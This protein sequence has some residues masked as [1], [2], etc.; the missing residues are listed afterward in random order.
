MKKGFFLF[1]LLLVLLKPSTAQEKLSSADKDAV[2]L[3]KNEASGGLNIHSNGWGFTFRRGWH[4]TGY[5]KH[6]LEFDL[7]SMRHPKQYKQANPY[8]QNSKP[9]YFGKLNYVFL[10]RG[11]YGRQN[12]LYSKGER[13]GVE[14]RY[15][16]GIGPV[17]A[18][19]KPVY[20]KVVVTR[21][22]ND[23]IYFE[24]IRQYTADDPLLSPEN[25]NG[26]GP[27]F[28]G[29]DKI[30]LYPGGWGRFSLSFE[31]AGWHEKITAIETGVI[32][33]YFPT[34]V[35][36]MAFN[37]NQNMMVNFYISLLWGKKY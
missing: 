31:Y 35:P 6:L 17:L 2:I 25:I 5:K 29:F 4:L 27:F 19:A 26:P 32:V 24:E 18:I 1:F 30:K 15:H 14:V 11:G 36:I 34:A 37:K 21:P 12:I 28:K 22:P 10:L 13:S 9:F 23:S 16:Y 8:F 7:V 33:D 20:L 3:Y